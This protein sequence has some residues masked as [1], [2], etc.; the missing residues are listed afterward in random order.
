MVRLSTDLRARL[1]RVREALSKRAGGVDLVTS[2][3]VARTGIR[4]GEA[5]WL[6]WDDLDFSGR[7]VQVARGISGGR[8]ELPTNGKGRTV[9]MS[10]ALRDVLQRPDA[11][12]KAQALK[13]GR[14]RSD[15]MFPSLEGTPLDRA[16]VEK[17][18][19]R[20]LKKAG[21]PMHFTPPE[22]PVV[23]NQAKSGSRVAPKSLQVVG[24][25]RRDRTGDLLIA[26]Q[27]LSQ[28]S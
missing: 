3:V 12:T 20:A 21:L 9:D 15:W 11:A 10:L 24:G 23:A 19:K 17:P 28:L 22:S 13:D 18:F 27:A 6:Q 14:E 8:V 5:F 26:N 16:N 4:L 2:H 25:P 1:E 7:K